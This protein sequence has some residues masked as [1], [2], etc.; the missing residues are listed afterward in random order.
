MENPGQ[1][2]EVSTAFVIDKNIGQENIIKMGDL[3]AQLK[4]NNRDYAD[5][6]KIDDTVEEISKM[7]EEFNIR[8]DEKFLISLS[9]WD[10]PETFQWAYEISEEDYD[11]AMMNIQYQ[12]WEI[13]QEYVISGKNNLEELKKSIEWGLGFNILENENNEKVKKEF[14]LSKVIWSLKLEN[15]ISKENPDSWFSRSVYKE[16]QPKDE[17]DQIADAAGEWAT[18]DMMTFLQEKRNR[19]SWWVL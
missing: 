4:N 10:E 1:S 12:L 14:Q 8:M 7:F 11:S 6:G 17:S 16:S 5:W 3:W 9:D 13:V 19:E 2:Q 18:V 15:Q